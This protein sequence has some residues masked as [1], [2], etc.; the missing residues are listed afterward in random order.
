MKVVLS[1]N[2]ALAQNKWSLRLV[3]TRRAA[4]Y[5]LF[6]AATSHLLA[7]CSHRYGHSPFLCEWNLG[8]S[9]SLYIAQLIYRKLDTASM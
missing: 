9:G 7:F 2:V 1:G 3:A 4:A 5:Y 8:I 6:R